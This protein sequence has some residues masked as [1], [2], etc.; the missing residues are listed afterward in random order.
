MIWMVSGITFG[1]TAGL[2]WAYGF[3]IRAKRR[4]KWFGDE[5][6]SLRAAQNWTGIAADL[7]L[8]RDEMF[9]TIPVLHRFLADAPGAG[10]AR[11]YISQSGM[12]TKPAKTFPAERRDCV[13]H[14]PH[15]CPIRPHLSGA[16]SGSAG[17]FAA[18]GRG[19]LHAPETI[20][21]V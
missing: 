3:C 1:V 13:L 15:R 14:V 4:K 18:S 11:N 20:E 16:S 12:K 10:W 2:S 6:S 21:S 8:V 17:V 7:K 5:S 19:G 9:S